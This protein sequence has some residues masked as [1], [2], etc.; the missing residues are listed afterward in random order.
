MKRTI[1]ILMAVSALVLLAACDEDTPF[2]YPDCIQFTCAA[3]KTDILVETGAGGGEVRI[4]PGGS[5]LMY[6]SSLLLKAD[7]SLS[8]EIYD[9][10]NEDDAQTETFNTVLSKD[11]ISALL[12]SLQNDL[13]NT[14]GTC[15]KEDESSP[16]TDAFPRWEAISV[17]LP[18]G[19][20][21]FGYSFTPL[22]SVWKPS[23][24]GPDGLDDAARKTL[25]ELEAQYRTA[26]GRVWALA[27]AKKAAQNAR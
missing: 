3:E 22:D 17:K 7:G 25:A 26:Y 15:L 18:S 12:A 13:A 11:E 16:V 2:H 4:V 10:R 20:H 19:I 27:R 9:E 14:E 6:H 8:Y 21:S 24:P 5:V 1:M 23:C